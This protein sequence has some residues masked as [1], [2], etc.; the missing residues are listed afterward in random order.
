VFSVSNV[1]FP[2]HPSYY[3]PL[4]SLK[5]N[6][7]LTVSDKKTLHSLDAC[8]DYNHENFLR[9]ELGPIHYLVFSTFFSSTN[10]LTTS[11]LTTNLLIISLL[12]I[13][14]AYLLLPIKCQPTY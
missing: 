2:T 3:L 6:E 10:L 11:L 8:L 4:P 5:V 1:C 12:I 13:N 9:T 14:Q 7:N